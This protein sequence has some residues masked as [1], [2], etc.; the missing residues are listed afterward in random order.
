MVVRVL[1]VAVAF[2]ALLAEPA[3]A[4][5]KR[6]A[7]VAALQVAL[8]ATGDYS[9]TV[10]GIRGPATRAA[11]AAFQ[12]RHG[13]RADGTAG[14]ATRKELGRLGRP[15]WGSRTLRTGARGWDVAMLQFKLALRGFPSG[16]FDGAFGPRV[17]AAVQRF[18]AWARVTADGVAGPATRR[19]LRRKPPQSPL[20]FYRPVRGPVG[21]RFGPRHDRF[22]SGVDFRVGLGVPTRAAGRGCVVS[23][24]Y[25]P[26]GYGNLVVIQHRKSVTTWYAH[27]SSIAVSP[28]QCVTGGDLIGRV[29]STGNST[30]PHAHFEIRVRGAVVD[31]LPA[32]L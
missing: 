22:H 11:V 20:R 23:A 16:Y 30:G 31:P 5:T 32:F 4:H 8:R 12:R 28:G 9:G 3:F 17:A 6:S 26:S 25:D 29:G 10:D 18:Q 2:A 24:G 27:L 7:G 14:R 15:R 19:A 13:L 21:D 1:A